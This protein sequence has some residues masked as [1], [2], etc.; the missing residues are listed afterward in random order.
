MYGGADTAIM[1]GVAAL[2][3]SVKAVSKRCEG[4]EATGDEERGITEMAKSERTHQ[5]AAEKGRDNE[6]A[7]PQSQPIHRE[8]ADGVAEKDAEV[9][10]H[11]GK[12]SSADNCAAISAGHRVLESAGAGGGIDAEAMVALE[13]R[14]GDAKQERL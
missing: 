13:Q 12:M 6:E 2:A 8:A 11:P 9:C 1:L 4:S 10:E 14:D 5:T 3:N 7:E